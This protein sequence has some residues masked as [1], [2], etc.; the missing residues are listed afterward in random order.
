METKTKVIL[1]RYQV[2]QV[3][4]IEHSN[5]TM[6]AFIAR[7]LD[8]AEQEL[9]DDLSNLD[10]VFA[11][12]PLE[13]Y[14]EILLDV[15]PQWP[16]LRALLPTMPDAQIQ[17][18]W[19][20]NHGP[21]LLAQSVA[22][23]KTALSYSPVWRARELNLKALDYGCGW[24]R[25][26][27][28]MGKF[29]PLAQLEGVDPWDR[30]IQLCQESNIRNPLAVSQYLPDTLPTVA[31]QFDLIYAFS[32]FTHLSLYA[33]TACLGTLR[34]Y[35]SPSGVLVATV[36]PIEYWAQTPQPEQ[37]QNHLKS[38]YA[39]V[40]HNFHVRSPQGEPIYGDTSLEPHKLEQQ[41][42]RIIGIE[43]NRADPMQL[44]VAL[45]C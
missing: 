11:Q 8:K 19:T 44:I 31:N 41:G 10:Q 21:A 37:A 43:Q 20:G 35:L 17:T 24:G 7:A 25:L 32:V 4:R 18:N 13:T 42:L 2:C 5:L 45:T 22:F 26:L 39:Y 6:N 15:P 28:L 12:V 40:P 36:R 29:Y 34:R 14:G 3:C 27:R 38:G 33:G 1:I 30:S 23:V 9:L 16:R